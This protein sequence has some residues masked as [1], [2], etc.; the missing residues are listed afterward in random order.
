MRGCPDGFAG[1]K[2]VMTA[3]GLFGGASQALNSVKYKL[4]WKPHHD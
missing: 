4:Q 1:A 2:A 3:Q